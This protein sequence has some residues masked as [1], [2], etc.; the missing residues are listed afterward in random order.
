MSDYIK[1]CIK[2]SVFGSLDATAGGRVHMPGALSTA[3]IKQYTP[4][5]SD[6]VENMEYYQ[7]YYH[8]TLVIAMAIRP[9]PR[10]GNSK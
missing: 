10:A 4:K 9:R 5:I 2:V 1:P 8:S 3:V 6:K 7:P